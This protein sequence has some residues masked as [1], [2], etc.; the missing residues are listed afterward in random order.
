MGVFYP[1]V[2]SAKRNFAHIQKVS[3]IP[4]K[5]VFSALQQHFTP[6]NQ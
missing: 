5:M 3:V 2:G 1:I 4:E 6:L